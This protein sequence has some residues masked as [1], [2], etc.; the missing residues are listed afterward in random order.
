MFRMGRDLYWI[1]GGQAVSLLANFFILKLLTS[2]L[3]TAEYGYFVL[4][5]SMVLFFRQVLYD[6]I[7]IIAG[8]KSIDEDF[9]G[10][11][12]LSGFPVIE[13]ISR[14]IFFAFVVVLILTA[15]IIYLFD[16]GYVL[17]LMMV[18]GLVYLVAN[19][20]QGIFINIINV[21]SK[22]KMAAKGVMAD[23]LIKLLAI[24][25]F[26]LV[27]ELNIIVVAVLIAM[28]SVLSYLYIKYV[29]N[30]IH[31]RRN[32]SRTEFYIV[33]KKLILLSAPL[34]P[35]IFLVAVK[36]VG[37]KI[38]MASF[39]GVEDLAAYNVLFQLGFVPIMM[40]IGVIQTYVSPGIYKQAADKENSFKLIGGINHQ[41]MRIFFFSCFC[42]VVSFFVADQIF[43]IL[44]GGQYIGYYKYLPYFVVAGA[45]GGIA[46]IL[47]TAII[48]MFESKKAGKIILGSVLLS[49][50][51]LA[52]SIVYL[53]F[54]GGVVGL[55]LSSLAS[56]IVFYVSLNAGRPK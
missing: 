53:G 52:V 12:L 26:F 29:A 16:L 5:A 39:I 54:V 37:D 40:I 9:L 21:L 24:A 42:I 45:L 14:R 38:F 46:A 50:V 23:S 48:A 1:I 27:G 36:S 51:I 43:L 25:L 31:E 28:S 13:F 44:V 17:F 33:S 49:I 19:G 15:P 7:S 4:W 41:V 3:S 20:P 2:G 6:P 11:H 56:V 18:V 55:I 22:R 10:V 8:K 35:S 30:G 47:N 32:I 34:F